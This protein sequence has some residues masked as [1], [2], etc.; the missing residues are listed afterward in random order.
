MSDENITTPTETVVET[1]A[2]T[3]PEWDGSFDTLADQ[4]WYASI[5]EKARPHIETWHGATK[6]LDFYRQLVDADP[7][8]AALLTG[9]AKVADLERQ[10]QEAGQSKAELE[11]LREEIRVEKSNQ[12]FRAFAAA[13]PEVVDDEDVYEIYLAARFKE[14]GTEEKALALAYRALGKPVPG[15]KSVEPITP[16]APEPPPTPKTRAVTLPKSEQAMSTS[17]NSNRGLDRP[18]Y[19]GLPL[20][21]ALRLQREKAEAAD[22]NALG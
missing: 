2:D 6:E 1:P 8:K 21:D 22:K 12:A 10:L 5:P 19:A 18:A 13:H 9:K 20:D 14:G 7:D 15:A 3:T 4:P 16:A 11:A 17:T